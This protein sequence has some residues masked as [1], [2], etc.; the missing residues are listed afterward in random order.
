MIK[1]E[2]NAVLEHVAANLKRL[3]AQNQMSQQMLADKSG[4]SRRMV[5]A[6]ENGNSNI[7]LAKL[8]Q[9]AAV[10]DASFA[11][12]VSPYDNE[13]KTKRNVLTWRG[14]KSG[15]EAFLSCSFSA[16]NQVEL[17]MWSIAPGDKYQAEPDPE[18]WYEMVHIIEGSLTLVFAH[19]TQVLSAGE[20]VVYSSAQPYSYQNNTENMLRFVRNVVG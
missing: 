20:S 6:L 5:A 8:A 15:S 13:G 7:S 16:E 1:D 19:E 17:W 2:T 10:L 9:L 18:G 4:I 3:R 14:E 12:I 11:H